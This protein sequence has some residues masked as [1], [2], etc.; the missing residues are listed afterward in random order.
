MVENLKKLCTDL[1]IDLEL[2]IKSDTR[3]IRIDIRDRNH[4]YRHKTE[5]TELIKVIEEIVKFER[6][7]A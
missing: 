2:T 1:G 5:S 3:Y 4:F 6:K 7:N